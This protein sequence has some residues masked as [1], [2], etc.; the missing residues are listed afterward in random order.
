MSVT[1][2]T[3]Y[4]MYLNMTQKNQIAYVRHI[5]ISPNF[6]ILFLKYIL[7]HFSALTL[8]ILELKMHMLVK[9]VPH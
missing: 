5:T 3:E 6:P 9:I 7:K 8:V 1:Y 4:T 2:P